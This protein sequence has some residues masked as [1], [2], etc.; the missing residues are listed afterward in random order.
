[1]NSWELIVE[2]NIEVYTRRLEVYTRR[3]KVD[4]GYLY[5]TITNDDYDTRAVAMCFVP[6]VDL[7]R[8]QSHLRDA[9][10]QGWK[11]GK[12]HSKLGIQDDLP[13]S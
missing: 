6:D 9:Y 7:A 1:M 2:E 4:G 11:D 13:S 8:Y 10:T 5:R 3:L 12:E